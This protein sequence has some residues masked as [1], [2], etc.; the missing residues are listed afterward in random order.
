[1]NATTQTLSVENI[2]PNL[3]AMLQQ[4]IDLGTNAMHQGNPDMAITFFRSA[5]AKIGADFP[6]YDHIN[7]NLLIAIKNRVGQL[8]KNDRASEALE[9]LEQALKIDIEGSMIED[10]TFRRTFADTVYGLGL[11]FFEN[12]KIASALRCY[13]RAMSIQPNPLYLVDLTN[14]RS[15]LKEPALLSDFTDEIEPRQLGRHIFIACVPKSASTFLKNVLTDLT[16]YRDVF[17]VYS[18]WQTDQEIYLPTIMEYA[19]QNTVTQQHCRASEANIQ[20]MQAFNIR[21]VILVRNIF[22]AV[23]SMVDFYR[24]GAAFNSYH[25]ADFPNLNEEKQVDLI[26]DFIVPW[27]LQFVASWKL[28]EAEDRLETYW[29]TYEELTKNKEDSI[30]NLLEFYGLGA[31]GSSVEALITATET[32]SRRNRFNKGVTGRGKS[33]LTDAQKQRIIALTEYYPATDFSSIGLDY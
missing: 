20:I 23:V 19:T 21:P 9:L 27:Y 30:K 14:T 32:E 25:R 12:T 29:L 6:F 26:I 3:A 2:D 4:E 5:L 11:Q 16:K 31:R 10:A 17:S 7:N 1:M 24:Q 8:L 28:A 13:R 22:D 33:S 18:A 15:I